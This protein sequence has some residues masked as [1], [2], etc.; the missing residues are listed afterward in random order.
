MRTIILTVLSFTL[1][2]SGCASGPDIFIDYSTS[3][4]F[5]HYKTYRWY[6]DVMSSKEADYR[7]YNSQD[8]RVRKYFNKELERLG[9]RAV[10][11]GEPDF[12]I[13]YH[14]SKQENLQI[15]QFSQY[16]SKGV[17]GSVA[18]GT[19]GQSVSIGYSSGSK[20]R[21]YKDGTVVIDI[22]NTA[23][24]E[25][26]WRGIAEG[27]LPKDLSPKKRDQ[28]AFNLSKKLLGEFHS[29]GAGKSN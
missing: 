2:L 22:I 3:T 5:S 21:V 12:L 9:Y 13:N 8:K 11:S 7:Q 14:I 26:A 10:N 6:D 16:S 29:I 17:H 15:D 18:A 27:R 19:Y 1:F 25:V 23:K 20:P 4:D 24:S 28:I